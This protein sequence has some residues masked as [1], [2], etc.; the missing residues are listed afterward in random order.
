MDE[1]RFDLLVIG[2]GP[3]GQKG[4]LAAA[5]RGMRV[6]VI[7]RLEALDGP[8]S[9]GTIP[10]KTLR[11][12][13]LFLS[14]L[15]QRPFFKHLA[16]TEELHQDALLK[17]VAAVQSH[18]IDVT[19]AQLRRNGV[20]VFDGTA[21]FSDPHTLEVETRG[22]AFQLHGERILIACG[23]RPARQFEIPFDGRRVIDVDEV[24][25][26]QEVPGTL[27]VVGGGVMGLEYA[28]IFATL[29]VDVILVEIQNALLD[30]VDQ[31]IIDDLC[32]HLRNLG[33]V[34]R[35][36]ERVEA[37]ELQGERV[38]AQLRSGRKVRGDTLLHTVGRQGNA[39]RLGLEATGLVADARGRVVVDEHFRTQVPHIYA[40]GAVVRLGSLAG[41]SK[42]H[43]RVAISHMLGETAARHDTPLGIYTVPEI[44]MIGRTEQELRRRGERF[45]SGMAHYEDLARGQI[46]RSSTGCLKLLF[47]PDDRRLLGVHALGEASTELIHIGQA[48]L[49][50]GGT[51]DYFRDASFNHPTFAEAYR[52]AAIDGLNKLQPARR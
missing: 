38:V 44:S 28:S 9:Q 3:A 16:A 6:A 41:T 21:C 52:M 25:A 14:A 17:R 37:V 45:A 39:D 46:I 48:V 20:T 27:V 5:W 7:D 8:V 19:R 1:Q 23:S 18:G 10:S 43:A 42:D 4:A 49:Q 50:F 34:F 15:R 35:L 32:L 2:A 11:E 33:V 26:L 24:G 30:F 12:A 36:G 13:A 40:A 31:Q 29:G 51:V 22:G 47:D